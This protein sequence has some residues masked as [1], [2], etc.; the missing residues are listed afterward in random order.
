MR[1][2]TSSHVK[3]PLTLE[4]FFLH[5]KN[6]VLIATKDRADARE[7]PIAA[8]VR[9]AERRHQLV[10]FYEQYEELVETLCDGAQYGPTSGL[11]SR[12]A[13]SR[14]WMQEHY[15]PI[16]RYLAAYL[17]YTPEDAQAALDAKGEGGDAFEALFAAPDL[18]TFLET[19]DGRMISRLTRTREALN[20]YGTHLREMSATAV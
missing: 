20:L 1:I 9:I 19:D 2:G 14:A 7:H 13:K 12:Y 8:A 15:A 6:R 4:G 17:Q 5:L 16:R 3:P 10:E 11:E 18:Q